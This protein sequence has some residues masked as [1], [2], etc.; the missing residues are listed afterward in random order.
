MSIDTTGSFKGNALKTSQAVAGGFVKNDA[1]GLFSYDNGPPAAAPDGSIW[2]FIQTKNITVDANSVVF[3]GLDGDVDDVYKLVWTGVDYPGATTNWQLRPNGVT[4][5]LFSQG[6]LHR[7]LVAGN[8]VFTFS[9]WCMHN[10]GNVYF[11]GRAYVS[12]KTGAPRQ[13][14]CEDQISEKATTK[15]QK[16]ILSGYWSDTTT[17]ITSLEV[18]TPSG[19]GIT[20]GSTWSLWRINR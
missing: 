13:F 5:G 9:Y 11:A 4:T 20:A 8:P 7:T 2:D 6:M 17:N 14:F 3:S 16:A 12:A 18:N 1:A 19:N 10:E 15:V